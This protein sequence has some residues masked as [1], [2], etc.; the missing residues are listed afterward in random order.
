MSD[1]KFHLIDSTKLGTLDETMLTEL[2]RLAEE[3]HKL[4]VL[5]EEHEVAQDALWDALL[6]QFGERVEE[7]NAGSC[8][9]ITAEGDVFVDFCK[10]PVCQAA[11]H[12]M[13]VTEVVEEMHKSSLLPFGTLEAHRQHAKAVDFEKKSS[14]K[15]MN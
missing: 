1:D 12:G 13:S 15:L 2:E 6:R 3:K 8:F 7:L 9:R 5:Q 11:L 14:K 4:E 10:C